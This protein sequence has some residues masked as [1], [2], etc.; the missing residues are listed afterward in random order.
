MDPL[1][2]PFLS[3]DLIALGPVVFAVVAFVRRLTAKQDG[4]YRIDGIVAVSILSLLVS[5]GVVF[6]AFPA[7]SLQ[8]LVRRVPAL[9]LL[10]VGGV[11]GLKRILGNEDISAQLPG[12]AN[13]TLI[14]SAPVLP[15]A[16][17]S[18]E[19]PMPDA[20]KM[21]LEPPP[22]PLML[23]NPPPAVADGSPS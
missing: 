15:A 10:A 20:R 2:A 19:P 17:K 1:S 7:S 22:D 9:F 14:P 4:S 11:A 21:P 18:V 3:P 12:S 5:V 8:D 6:W 13:T 16:S 23:M